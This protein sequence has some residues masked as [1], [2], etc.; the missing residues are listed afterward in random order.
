MEDFNTA[1]L[2]HRKY[3]DLAAYEEEKRTGKKSRKRKAERT[4]DNMRDED[5][6]R[7]SRIEEREKERL[8]AERTRVQALME[9]LRKAKGTKDFEQ[10]QNRVIG[11]DSANPPAS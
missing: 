4:D 10:V 7:L 11:L 6:V 3:Y 1:T 5:R 9:S 8:D 2:P